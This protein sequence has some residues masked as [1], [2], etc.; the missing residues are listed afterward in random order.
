MLI[1]PM[2][3]RVDHVVGVLLFVNRKSE[4][5]AIIRNKADADRYVLPYTSR[6]VQVARALASQAAISIE[7]T[8]LYAQIEN[9]LDN[10]VKAAALAID[11][12]DPTTAGHSVRVATLVT[13]LAAAVE[14]DGRGVHRNVHFS[15][16]QM[17]EL[18]FAALLHDFGKVAVREELLIK[19]KKLPLQLWER[20]DSRFDLIRRTMEVEYYR[21]AERGSEADFAKSLEELEKLRSAVRAANEPSIEAQA[22]A[23]ALADIAKRTFRRHDG[24]VVPYLTPDE[25]RYLQLS[26]G[27]LDAKER[28]AVE[29]HVDAT[30]QF[31][32]GIPWTDDLKNLI[33]YAYGHHEKL[34][35]SGYPRKLRGEEIPIQTRIMTIADIFDALTASDRPYKPAVDA[36]KALDILHSEA[37]AGRLDPELIRVMAESQVYSRI[38]KEDWRQL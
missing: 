6:E 27:T 4:R 29:A 12:R 2:I 37:E 23:I 22:P 33:T 26:T 16:Q 38:L 28:A 9:M 5:S 8:K 17:R 19:A 36:E 32:V 15:R 25:L 18:H 31:L 35:G 1:V 3:D 24:S 10:F 11:Q 13:D 14:R 20:V 21:N 34:D 30:F 7:N